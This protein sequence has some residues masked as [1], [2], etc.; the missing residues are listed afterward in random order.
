[1]PFEPSELRRST[2]L[3]AVLAVVLLGCAHARS[4]ATSN[5][6]SS[7]SDVS[8]PKPDNSHKTADGFVNPLGESDHGSLFG[9]L[10]A[11]FRSGKWA[12]Y[13]PERYRVPTAQPE[14]ADQDDEPVVTWIG[15]STVLLQHRGLNVMTDPVFS[16]YASPFSFAGPKRITAPAVTI[17]ELPRIDVV[18]ISHNHYD[19]LD[20]ASVQ[21]L[22]N[23]PLYFV[24]LG[25]KAWMVDKG[26]AVERVEELDWW[27]SRKV[28]INGVEVEV[29][30]TPTQH[31]SG[32][33]LFDRD[34]TLW[35]SWAVAWGGFTSWF[36]GDTGYNDLQFREIGERLPNIDLGIIP[37]GAYAPQWFMGR[38]HVNPEEALQIHQDIGARQSLGIHWGTFILTAEEI[39]EPPR[40]LAQA[41]K[42]AG[43]PPDSF[44]VF[45]VGETRRYPLS[46]P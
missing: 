9:F 29:T 7:M 43:L 22:G 19:H 3:W 15:H 40:R 6:V 38:I 11:R 18:V 37:V 39:D 32:R 26:I 14:F 5:S 12:R 44:S 35:A 45:A 31:F 28:E 8:V 17:E 36:G 10:K 2:C 21:A 16:E 23:A 4:A 46:V 41:L 24:P 42:D 25:V 13:E 20:T 30:A 33:G 1:M 34:K 27:E